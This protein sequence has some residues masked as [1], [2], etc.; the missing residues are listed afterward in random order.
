MAAETDVLICGSGSAGLCAAV[1]LA[2]LG[3]NFIVLE[4]RDGPLRIG[5]ADGIQCRTVEVFESFNL[6]GELTK[7]AYWVNEVCFWSAEK[8]KSTGEE[9]R[10]RIARSGRTADVKSG[11]SWKPHVIMNQAHL[12][13][14]LVG[15]VERH[16]G[17]N[18]EYGVAV[19]D[20]IVDHLL[21][22]DPH[23]MAITV[24]AE[25]D[26]K[27]IAYKAKYVL[28]RSRNLTKNKEN[29]ISLTSTVRVVMVHIALSVERLAIKWLVIQA[30]LFGL[31]QFCPRN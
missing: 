16:S 10:D 3:I 6:D 21:V 28:V 25:R 27:E 20:V 9:N 22:Q 19:K 23:A 30:M 13:G 2:R 1:W 24:T 12:N 7:D 17:K 5:Q 11:I 4:K 29:H 18:I 26:G 8:D 14:L 31:V 15:D